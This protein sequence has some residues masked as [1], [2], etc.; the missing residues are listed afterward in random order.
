[1]TEQRFTSETRRDILRTVGAVGIA[2]SIGVGTAVAT[3]DSDGR[4]QW[5]D[6]G[7]GRVNR[8]RGIA[9]RHYRFFQRFT[10]NLGLPDDV[11][12]VSGASIERSNRTSP[13]NIAMY[14]I[15][16]VGAEELGFLSERRTRDRLRTVVDTLESVETWNGLFLRWYDIRNGRPWVE[17]HSGSKLISTVDNG[18]LTAALGVVSQR[19]EDEEL[20]R[21]AR[22]LVTAQNYSPFHDEETGRLIGS[23]DYQSGLADWEYGTINSEPRV[24]SYCAIG[25]GDI[26]KTHWWQPNRTY[27]PEDTW[28]QQTAE[29]EWQT[30][31]G[32]DVFEGHYDYNGTSYVPSWGGAQFEALMPSL[33]MK[34]QELGTDAFGK[35]NSNWTQ[36]QIEFAA[37]QGWPV[38]GLSPCGT[39]DG[40]GAFGVPAQGV[41]K[42]N[43]TPGPIVTP[44][45]TFLA[46]DY[47]P[48]AVIENVTQLRKMGI[49]GKYGFYDSIN[50]ETGEVTEK[51]YAL[52][53]GMS[54]GAIANHLEDGV[55]RDYFHETTMGNR[56]EH[57]LE[58]EEFSI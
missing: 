40:Y 21:R 10:S 46:I 1:M 4:D 19:Y 58:R 56:P 14:I 26:P 47:A 53:Q 18:H 29:G 23:Y 45:A 54:I 3:E 11:V 49:D 16:T 38:W 24:A 51:F 32:V 33:F 13:S 2:S 50:A 6:R 35:N 34:E 55:I 37:D 41:W 8:L 27:T 28:T 7:D 43:Y 5:D 22:A 52:D 42:D 57:L 36:V 25:K 30:Y 12:D 9:R 20:G 48:D 15:S 39:P 17:T 31:D 44:H